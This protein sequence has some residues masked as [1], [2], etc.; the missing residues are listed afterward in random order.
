MTKSTWFSFAR[1]SLL[2]ILP[3]FAIAATCPTVED[4]TSNQSLLEQHGWA[5]GTPQPTNGTDIMTLTSKI[6]DDAK[7]IFCDYALPD[8]QLTLT[9]T[10]G[11]DANKTTFIPLTEFT[12]IARNNVGSWQ[13]K[14]CFIDIKSDPNKRCYFARHVTFDKIK[15]KEMQANG[16][17]EKQSYSVSENC[18]ADNGIAKTG[19]SLCKAKIGDILPGQ[20]QV[21]FYSILAKVYDKEL[22]VMRSDELEKRVTHKSIPAIISPDGKLH[23][24]DSHHR[25][26]GI[27][28]VTSMEQMMP[29]KIVK[30]YRQDKL[31]PEAYLKKLVESENQVFLPEMIKK[32]FSIDNATNFATIQQEY[33]ALPK[34]LSELKQGYYRDLVDIWD[35]CAYSEPNCCQGDSGAEPIASCTAYNNDRPFFYQFK[36][37]KCLSNNKLMN[38]TY[39]DGTNV[40]YEINKHYKTLEQDTANH[41]G[42]NVNTTLLELKYKFQTNPK[43]LINQ[44][45]YQ[46][47]KAVISQ[48][49]TAV[50]MHSPISPPETYIKLCGL[51]SNELKEEPIRV[52]NIEACLPPLPR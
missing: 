24:T 49:S 31:S 23:L 39:V 9:A 10:I 41:C 18:L 40:I 50:N 3:C 1:T 26:S 32:D 37:G 2:L 46:E 28:L 25:T 47:Y 14:S 17:E 4:M 35:G 48:I 45:C 42:Y 27:Y 8:T 51:P 22:N 11:E 30:D 33:N 36:W 38:D 13:Q 20:A 12:E 15:I 44:Q 19:L 34:K 16:C 29:I 7:T 6:S 52:I 21:G 5:Y 43:L